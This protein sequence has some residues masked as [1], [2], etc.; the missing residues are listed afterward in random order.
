[1]PA[2]GVI[3]ALGKIA[4]DAVLRAQGMRLSSRRFAHGAWHQLDDGRRLLDTY[5]CSRYDTNTRRLTPEMF[6]AVFAQL[7]DTLPA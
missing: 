2:D 7:R 6:R 4:H 1:M 5:H 3:L